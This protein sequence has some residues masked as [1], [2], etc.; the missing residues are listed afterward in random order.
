MPLSL[1]DR[2]PAVVNEMDVQFLTGLHMLLGLLL[3]FM[4]LSFADDPELK[5]LVCRKVVEEI[6]AD[7]QSVNP[8]KK[9]AVGSYRIDA[10]GNQKRS[11]ILY[12]RS[13]IHIHDVL[14]KVCSKLEDY[15]QA[16]FKDTGERTILKLVGSDGKMNPDMG[17]VDFTPDPDLNK[18]LKYYCE[19]LVEDHEDDIVHIF[20]KDLK[21]ADIELCTK[22]SGLC[23]DNINPDDDYSF[24]DRDEL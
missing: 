7:V 24:E 17:K 16:K 21:D 1:I 8:R 18:M 13:E 20:T 2:I 23:Q 14:E 4:D 6:E 15:A 9:I 19:N 5:C 10:E 11:E 22:A 3:I 12:A